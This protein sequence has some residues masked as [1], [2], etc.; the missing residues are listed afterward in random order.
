MDK[1]RRDNLRAIIGKA[2]RSVEESLQRQLVGYG[3]FTDAPALAKADLPL[4]LDQE[5]H[6]QRVLDAVSRESRA[7]GSVQ[8]ITPEAVARYIREAGGTW[9]NRLAAL[10]ALEARDL[11]NPAAAFVSDEYGGLSPRAA[12]LRERAAAEGKPLAVDAALQAGIRDACE[13]LSESVRV[14]FDL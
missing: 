6:Y 12:R 14:L 13:E 1:D 10:R 5:A 9:V 11:L 8:G 4:R 2:R 7:T 3:L